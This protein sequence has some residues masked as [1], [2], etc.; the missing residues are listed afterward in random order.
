MDAFSIGAALE[1]AK[2]LIVYAD[3][4]GNVTADTLPGAVTELAAYAADI[5]TQLNA[6]D[7]STDTKYSFTMYAAITQALMRSYESRIT[8]LETKVTGLLGG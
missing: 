6:L 2:A 8:I 3:P 4:N 7:G 5:L 1:L